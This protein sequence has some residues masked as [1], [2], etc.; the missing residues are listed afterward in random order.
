MRIGLHVVLWG[1]GCP[2]LGCTFDACGLDQSGRALFAPRLVF[3]SC[4]ASFGRSGGRRQRMPTRRI[5]I[6]GAREA[7]VM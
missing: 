5:G 3:A 2:C 7:G 1:V 4:I 6:I